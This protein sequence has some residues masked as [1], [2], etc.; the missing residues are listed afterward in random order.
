MQESILYAVY[1]PPENRLLIF[2][3][4]TQPRWTTCST[5]VDYMTVAFGD[6]FGNV[7][8]NRL[9]AKISDQVD[10]DPT[11][12]GILHE[13]GALMGAP[14]KTKMLAAFHV[15]DI[16]TGIHK[17]SLVAG[18]REVLLYTCL[19]GTIG[20]LVPFVSKEDVDFISTLEQHMRS[21]K[22]ALVGRD[23]LAWRGYYVPVKAVVDGDLCEQFARL[24]AGKQAE[25]QNELSAS[26]GG[27]VPFMRHKL[28]FLANYDRFHSTQ[29]S[30]TSTFTVPTV[31]M[32]QGDFT[33]LNGTGLTGTGANNPPL[34]FNPL[35]TSCVGSVCTRQPFQGLK[36]G[37][38][39]NNVIPSN[40]LSP[41]SQY[42]QKFLPD[43]N[44]AGVANNFIT[45]GFNGF[46]NWEIVAKVDYDVTSKQRISVAYTRGLRQSIGYG[47]VL[48]L[49]YSTAISSVLHPT[50]A[51]VE[52][53]WTLTPHI[54]NQ[55]N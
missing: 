41:I 10:E 12:A 28:F 3:D 32:K 5:M 42:E 47:T 25:H 15:G 40:Y 18:G 31:L 21:E 29:T 1:K 37:V 55:F 22:L 53:A 2:A 51:T 16:V 13:K 4:D 19:H 33:E 45:S 23:H 46:D 44:L 27:P 39:T 50:M 34:I 36:N 14:H 52:H 24:P 38:L 49:P 9:D 48:P 8:V 35:S 43:P 6:K 7:L 17:I 30:G 11:G 54:V 26:V 20:I